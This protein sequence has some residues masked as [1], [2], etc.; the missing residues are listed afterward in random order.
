MLLG[1]SKMKLLT[2]FHI[3]ICRRTGQSCCPSLL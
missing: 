2:L 1:I 3:Y